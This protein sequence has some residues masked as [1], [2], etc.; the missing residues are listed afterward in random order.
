MRNGQAVA[1][2]VQYKRQSLETGITTPTTM[3]KP[4]LR[5]SNRKRK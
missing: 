1:I 3:S 5:I 2:Y 4:F